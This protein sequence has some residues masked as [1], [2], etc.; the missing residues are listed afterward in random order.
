MQSQ[1]RAAV[2]LQPRRSFHG[3]TENQSELPVISRSALVPQKPT[4]S[5]TLECL[6]PQAVP[7]LRPREELKKAGNRSLLVS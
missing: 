5:V 1:Y 4:S 7:A 6:T 3:Q 2:F